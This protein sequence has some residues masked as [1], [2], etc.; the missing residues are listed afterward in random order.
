MTEDEFRKACRKH[1]LT[2][3]YSDDSAVY[4]A[5]AESERKLRMAA[6]EIG[7]DRARVIWN[8]VVAEKINDEDIR[9]S[10]EW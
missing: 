2:Y 9:K 6:E 10:Y 4:F 8:E 7:F 3:A 1:D 5:G